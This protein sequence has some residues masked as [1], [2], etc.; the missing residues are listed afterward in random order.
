[1]K[2]ILFFSLCFMALLSCSNEKKT[3]SEAYEKPLVV[4]YY[5]RCDKSDFVTGEVY[6]KHENDT[7]LPKVESVLLQD[8][9]MLESTVNNNILR[10]KIDQE[11]PKN[12]KY[13][14][15]I[16]LPD[17]EPISLDLSPK[18]I[19]SFTV[20]EG[21]MSKSKGFNMEWQGDDIQESNETMILLITDSKGQ[22]MGLN[23]IGETAASGLF[24][25]PV[26]LQFFSAGPATLYLVRKTL[27]QIPKEGSITQSAEL[28]YYTDEIKIEIVE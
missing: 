10:F 14:F 20:K 28:E 15:K 2:K 22:S 3:A 19:K 21:V 27:I 12:K 4:N 17:L 24:I 26:Q 11:F 1:M 23:R 5:L 6:L 7:V 25:D 9:S 18:V 13:N 8:V 16:Q